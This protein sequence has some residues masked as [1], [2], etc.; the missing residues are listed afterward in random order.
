MLK[1][2]GSSA[3][4]GRPNQL[5]KVSLSK[6]TCSGWC[7]QVLASVLTHAPSSSLL[8]RVADQNANVA[9]GLNAACFFSAS[10]CS[11]MSASIFTVR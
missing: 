5:G 3:G 9:G 11:L 2:A 1:V 7:H 4:S 6:F 10:S 8:E